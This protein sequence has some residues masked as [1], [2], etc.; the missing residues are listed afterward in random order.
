MHSAN[1][2]SHPEL[3]AWLARDVVSHGYD[4]R[5]LVRGLVLSEAYSRSSRWDGADPPR[6]SLFAVALVRPLTA[7]QLATSLR[8][9]TAD[10][11]SLPA[12]FGSEPFEKRIKSLEESGR[13]L[14]SSF[15]PSSGDAQIGVAEA[16]L[17]SNSKRFSSELLGTGAGTL[18]NRL[19][20]ISRPTDAVDIA[21]RNVLSRPP[22]Q[23][24]L[25]ALGGYLE[26]RTDRPDDARRQ[27]VWV[28]LTDSEFRFN[29]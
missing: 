19:E 1:P 2:A 7:A 10:P 22:D 18:V 23:E 16:L 14:T 8:V 4:L 13:P 12:D 5:R 3:L 17:F 9:A 25:R 11:A 26:G 28:L 15:A 24:E 29:H 27:L 21:V 20:Q 6:P